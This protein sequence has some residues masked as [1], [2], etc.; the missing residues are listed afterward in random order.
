MGNPPYTRQEE[1]AEISPQDRQYKEKI[2]DK[3][4]RDIKGRKI[5]D[6]PQRAGIYAYFFVHGAKFLHQGG[7]FGLVVSESWLD[8]DYGK[9]LQEF[10]LNHY[11][12]SAIIG[13]KVERWFEDADIN[14]CIVILEKCSGD[15]RRR[16]RE[17][18]PVRFVYL[19]KP[20]RYFIPPAQDIWEKQ[21]ERL[22]AIQDKF[23]K[24]IL[25]H[26]EP[27]EGDDFRIFPQKQKELWEEGFDIEP[28]NISAPSG[29]NISERQTFSLRFWKRVK[30][31]WCL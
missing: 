4:L 9:G 18:N 31:S 16:E 26:T 27:Y 29:A 24:T 3:A 15:E 19:K 1:I 11:Q 30:A 23:I 28:R 6:I 7:R 14:T 21:V 12:I 13:S 2:I 25:A 20:L 5:A 8:V 17:E 22:T 10:F